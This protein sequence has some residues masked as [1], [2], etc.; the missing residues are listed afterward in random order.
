MSTNVRHDGLF[1][2][3]NLARFATDQLGFLRELADR[4][5]IVEIS[6]LGKPWFVVSHP[7]DVETIL[8]KQA[9]V[10]GRDDYVDILKRTL[11]LGLLTSDGE[12]WK[13][14][15]KLMSQAFVPKRIHGY[16]AAMAR[17]TDAGLRSWRDGQEINIHQELS[18]LTMEVVSDVLFGTSVSG[19]DVD[20]VRDAMET[21]NEFYANS[22]E[23]V[24]KLPAWVP[25]PRNLR[26]KRAIERIDRLIYEI[27]ARRRSGE[28]REDLLGV[29]LAAQDDDGSG[30][31]D[32]QLRDEAITL[33]LAGHE[34]TALAL[35]HTLYLLSKHPEV[36]RKLQAE[37]TSVLGDRLPTADDVRSL[38]YVDRVLK[39]SMR[40][41]PPAWTTGREAEED[42]ELRGT[43]IPK[44]AQ[45]LLSQWIV[46][47]DPRF[48]PN[49]EGFD[50]DRW[51]PERAKGLPKF[52][53]FPFGG[54]PRVCIGNHFAVMEATLMLAIILQRF[55]VELLPTQRLE[56]RPSV[57]LRQRGPGLRAHIF[58]RSANRATAATDSFAAGVEQA[59]AL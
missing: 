53:Y 30:M 16:G 28:P 44:G 33:F 17:V 50:P 10:M 5:D 58:E 38:V 20:A 45:V 4:G 37:L 43:R 14:Q 2:L 51:A 29:L 19:H 6:M 21:I 57:T 11:G 24:T 27:I 26:M 23:A 8:V 36:E 1:G 47:R 12:L 49:P 34:T 9:R 55:R 40:L 7:D 59:R 54:G 35:S 32:Q 52:A 31:T 15:R 42:I 3:R 22:P 18:R 41:Y 46:H 56:L 48:F 13:R 25:T 39:E